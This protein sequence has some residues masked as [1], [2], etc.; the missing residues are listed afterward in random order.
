MYTVAPAV[1]LAWRPTV[2][3]LENLPR[4][5]GAVLASN[6]L[7]VADEYMLGST[8]P[9]HIAFWAKAEYFNTP[10]VRGWFFKMLMTGLGAI[11][12]RREGGRGA[13]TAFDAAIPA[14]QAGDLVGVY[15]EGT[16]SPDGRLYRGRTGMARLALLASVPIITVGVIGTEAVQPI[17]TL[18][19]KLGKKVTVRFGKPME[20]S[21][22]GMDSSTLR[23][24]TDEVMAQIQGLTGQVY[25]GRYAPRRDHATGKRMHDDEGDTGTAE[26][27]NT[28]R[29]T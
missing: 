27:P 12:V 3:G 15:P 2:E 29:D 9:R 25:V 28:S 13:L 23:A 7:S 17:G 20:F 10:G 1:R 6:H 21:D 24:I 16:R 11:E 5:G 26:E 14:L 22:R 4:T 18:I 19:P 8:V